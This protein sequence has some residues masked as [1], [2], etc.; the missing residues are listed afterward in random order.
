[1][2]S[3]IE[4][5]RKILHTEAER[6]YDNAAII[7]GLDKM[8]AFWEPQARKA[9]LDT[10]LVED[11]LA[12]LRHYPGLAL[13]ERKKTM[14]ELA[15]RLPLADVSPP[16]AVTPTASPQ[17]KSLVRQEPSTQK[18][19]PSQPTPSRSPT[20]ARSQPV[21]ERTQPPERKQKATPTAPAGTTLESPMTIISG[22]GPKQAERLD[23]LGI[24]SLGAALKAFP[25]RHVDFSALKSINR[26][27]YG[28]EVTVVGTIREVNVRRVRGGQ[29]QITQVIIGDG[30]GEVQCTWFNQPWMRDQFKTGRQLQ[31][32]GSPDLYL[33][34]LVF[35]SPEWEWLDTE[36]LHTGRLVPIYGLTKGLA[37]KAMRRIM[38]QAVNFAAPLLKESLPESTRSKQK[39][40]GLR[41]AV[42]G[43][44]FPDS[45]DDLSAAQLRLAFDELL[46]LL[47]GIRRQRADWQALHANP[48]PSAD[49]WMQKA[50]SALPFQLTGA[51]QRALADVR[52]D[53]AKDVPMNRLIQGDVG[54]GKTVIAALALAI[55]IQNGMQAAFMAPTSILAEQHYQS[56]QK[57]LTDLP[58]IDLGADG[59]AVRLLQ[60]STPTAEREAIAAGLQDGSVKV[61]IGTHALIQENVSFSNLGIAVVDEQHRFGVEQRAALR[62]KGRN[63]HLLVMTATP[64]PRSLALTVYGDLDLSIIDE[65]PPG[66]QPIETRLIY[67]RERER[68]YS[69]L[70]RHIERGRQ[71]F[72]I[73]P[74]VEESES[75]QAKA[76]VDEHARLSRTIY[77]DLR[78]GLLHGK[79]KP[80]EKDAVMAEFR[81][82]DLDMLVSTSVIE[83]GVDIPNAAVMLIEGANHFG[84]AQL[85]QFRGRVGRGE[86]KSYCLLM[87]EA[88]PNG[89]QLTSED[90]LD[91]RLQVMAATNDGFV[92]AEKDLELRGPGEFLGT[93]QA[94]Y[95]E[96]R[97]A[98]LTDLPLIDLAR[99]E[100]DHILGDDP[101]LEQP[102]HAQLAHLLRQFWQSGTGDV[103]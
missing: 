9:E 65:L 84:L 60:G 3:P 11:V 7:G 75:V 76:A 62:G 29:S 45:A 87:T 80:A 25:H 48:T 13:E 64:I 86:H 50:R 81:N 8:I 72:I 12:W 83:V 5:L 95:G 51:Q 70:R 55:G 101:E 78:L 88:P 56:V 61:L 24:G 54:S 21:P 82:G 4:N 39:L 99:R 96:L 42:L 14:H 37:S 31:I 66:R 59:A 16:S 67:P 10:A 46:L 53:M 58:G 33:G 41:E 1:M 73:C 98:R 93:R 26:L 102:Q 34:Q 52:A 92:L 18:V 89:S 17:R 85:H 74:L 68:A 63:P 44:H 30:T 38:Y 20:S 49:D 57:L 40:P 35:T 2:P 6:G 22:V 79:M 28:V 47:L 27:E 90:E 100:A 97:M 77:P 15:E 23:K 91:D 103:S 69:F 71:A 94:G 36:A 19:K 43:A 32:A